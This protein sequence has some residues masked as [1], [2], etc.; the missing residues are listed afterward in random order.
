VRWGGF[1][2]RADRIHHAGKIVDDVAVPE[3]DYAPATPSQFRRACCI[4]VGSLGVLAAVKLNDEFARRTGEIGDESADWMLPT[5][6]PA[7]PALA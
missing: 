6:F 5:E 7:E 4:G 1:E 3:S 2:R